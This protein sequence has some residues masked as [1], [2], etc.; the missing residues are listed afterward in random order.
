MK[1]GAIEDG[2]RV[3][4]VR[5]RVTKMR[6]PLPTMAAMLHWVRSGSLEKVSFA[7]GGQ[8]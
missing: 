1:A 3:V 4:V 7:N 5:M 2:G 8:E 6:A